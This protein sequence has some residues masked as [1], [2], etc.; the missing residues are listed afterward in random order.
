VIRTGVDMIEIERVR[1]VL[2]RH[3]DRFLQRVYTVDE[4]AYCANRVESLA[5]RFAAKEAIA[6][7]LGTGA[8]RDGICWTDLEVVRNEESGEPS[9]RLH[10]AAQAAA[11]RLALD[12]W[13]LSLSHS[14]AYAIA[15]V[16]ALSRE[17]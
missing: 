14:R 3:G 17:R 12:E 2:S 5:V 8:W 7:A 6:K 1:A 10:N 9:I 13:S 4:I 11:N 16:V 15:F